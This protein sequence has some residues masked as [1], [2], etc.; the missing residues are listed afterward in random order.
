[1]P[2]GLL[3]SVSSGEE[4]THAGFAIAPGLVSA[5]VVPLVVYRL[6]PPTLTHTPRAAEFARAELAKMGPAAKDAVPALRQSMAKIHWPDEPAQAL[7][8]IGEAAAAA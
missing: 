3:E 1:M 7:G 2:E 4:R 6:A 5:V 8:N